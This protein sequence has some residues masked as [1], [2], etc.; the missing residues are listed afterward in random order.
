MILT[1]HLLLTSEAF[2]IACGQVAMQ[3][4]R[5]GHMKDW[6]SSNREVSLQDHKMQSKTK[7]VLTSITSY[8]ILIPHYEASLGNSGH[9]FLGVVLVLALPLKFCND[10]SYWSHE[11]I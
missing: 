5:L 10:Q 2:L 9:S 8:M 4:P 6:L 11:V 1:S 7:K 3:V